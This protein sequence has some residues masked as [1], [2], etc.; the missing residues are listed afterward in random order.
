MSLK[1]RWALTSQVFLL[2]MEK[3]LLKSEYFRFQRLNRG[4][5]LLIR[6]SSNKSTFI[7]S[8]GVSWST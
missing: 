8:Q 1:K 5:F 7:F 6:A 4:L 2:N 3:N